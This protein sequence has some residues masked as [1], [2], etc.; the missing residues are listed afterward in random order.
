M[1]VKSF[2]YG[3]LALLVILF[4]GC[5]RK[6]KEKCESSYQMY[7]QVTGQEL[8]KENHSADLKRIRPSLTLD[9]SCA[10]REQLAWLIQLQPSGRVAC[11]DH[12]NKVAVCVQIGA[13]FYT[14]D[15]MCR[16]L[17]IENKSSGV[18]TSYSAC[19]HGQY[20]EIEKLNH[21]DPLQR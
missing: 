20:W 7:D 9:M 5:Q 11:W 6:Y 8:N 16:Q 2:G 19:Q 13:V 1:R 18:K 15:Q 17:E 4:W 12:Q 21:A 14:N 10:E 3:L